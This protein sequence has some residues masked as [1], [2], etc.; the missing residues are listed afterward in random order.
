M[1]NE[2]MKVKGFRAAAVAAGIRKVGRLDVG[3]IFSEVPAVA[4]GV[5][6]TNAVKA[7]PVLVDEAHIKGGRGRAIVVN[8]GCA[9]ACTGEVGMRDAKSTVQRVAGLFGISEDEVY[10]ASTGVIGQPLPMDR[11]L[12]GVEKAAA[13]LASNGLDSVASAIMTTDTFPKTASA[14]C[15]IGG[16]EVVISGMAKGAG[17]IHPNMATMLS[18]IVTDAA[19]SAAML[20][21]A[22]RSCV[23]K[24]FNRVTVDGDTST[25]DTLLMLANGAA[26]NSEINAPGEDFDAF[27][28]ALHQ[29]CL[30]LSRMIA[31]DGEG[32]TK[33]VEV[34]VKG[35]IDEADAERAAFAIAHSPLVKTAL[36]AEDA[37]WGRVLAAVGYSGARVE[38]ERLKLFFG[39]AQMVDKGMGLG[40]DAEAAVSAVMKQKEFVITVDLGLGDASATVWT[41]DLS[42]DYVKIN[43]EY[44]T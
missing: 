3:L 35:A 24:T 14:A 32:A 25:N 26:G 7:A 34:V 30:A 36:F 17:M 11:L 23:R 18:F 10:V 33:L 42:F 27:A 41:C 31:R 20:D 8:S 38:Q 44:R 37:N 5:F 22:L 19:I 28:S 2:L 13:E 12:S 15:T 1:T 21:K 43:A 16:R 29:V 9:N 39:E 4:A 6:T 40:P